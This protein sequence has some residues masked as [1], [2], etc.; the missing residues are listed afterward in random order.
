MIFRC[1]NRTRSEWVCYTGGGVGD[2]CGDATEKND[3]RQMNAHLGRAIAEPHPACSRDTPIGAQIGRRPAPAHWHP[4]TVAGADVVALWPAAA[5]LI[6]YYSTELDFNA[7]LLWCSFVTVNRGLRVSP[8]RRAT[9]SKRT[10][11]QRETKI[12]FYIIII[13]KYRIY[14]FK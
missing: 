8:R 13:I 1:K 12:K 3:G 7:L 2:R 14:I 11:G 9:P 4:S 10:R 6:N 5:V